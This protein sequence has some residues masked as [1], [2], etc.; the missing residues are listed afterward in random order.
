MKAHYPSRRYAIIGTTLFSGFGLVCYY[1]SLYRAQERIES[2]KLE[3]FSS[4]KDNKNVLKL[5]KMIDNAKNK[6]FR[7]KIEAGYDA[8]VQTHNII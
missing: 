6:P 5:E 7:E 4:K 1:L 2:E 8:A 3:Q